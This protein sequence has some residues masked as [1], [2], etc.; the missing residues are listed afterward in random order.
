[1]ARY[2]VNHCSGLVGVHGDPVRQMTQF[3]S[4]LEREGP[5]VDI[6]ITDGRTLASYETAACC[7]L[8]K[9][10]LTQM[11]LNSYTPPATVAPVTADSE[12]HEHTPPERYDLNSII[13][14][15][16]N[17]LETEQLRLEPLVVSGGRIL[18]LRLDPLEA[19][20]SRRRSFRGVFE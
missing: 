4:M 11:W 14:I 6:R 3:V 2:V 17:L 5:W 12:L 10:C 15:P 13:P 19:V 7:V 8:S 16:Q 1:M 20:T 18:R 9:L